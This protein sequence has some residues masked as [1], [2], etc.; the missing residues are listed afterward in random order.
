MARRQFN[1][2]NL[3]FLDVI[4]CG[5]GAVILFFMI[6]NSQVKSRSDQAS[7]DLQ[8]ESRLLEERIFNEQKQLVRITNTLDKT[9]QENAIIE[10]SV[11]ELTEIIQELLKE[12]EFYK[13]NS[14]ASD[15]DVKR[16][17][18]DVKQLTES[19]KRMSAQAELDSS[20]TGKSLREFIGEGDRQ[21]LT[22]LKLGG[23]HVLFLVDAS[24][25]MLG[26]TYVNVIRY[27]NMED[28]QKIKAPKW[29]Q[30][31]NSV[32][33]LTTRLQSGTKFQIYT[34]NESAASAIEDSQ[35]EWLEVD[36]GTTIKNAIE[37]LRSTVP[38]NG[39]SLIN[40]FEKIND[41]EP[42]PDNIFL[43]TDGLPTQGKRNPVS[44]TMVKPEQRIRYF[45]QALR[46]LPPIPVNVLLFPMDGDP[47][48]AEAYWRLAIRSKG[49][50]MAPSRDW[51]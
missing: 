28:S 48:A 2:F 39:T 15:D 43:L 7:S 26:R 16:L 29:R 46:E 38:Q 36:D 9:E 20:N 13:A 22:E 41:L 18:A 5:F 32:D 3:S 51:P 35:G 19:N 17:Q 45:E 37:E 50:F 34:F 6:I 44:E 27:R 14:L 23:K 1:V 10:G 49:S 31:V 12:I 33:W 11:D 25:S 30:T 21:Y 40:A 4:A 42:R 8:S 47:L 24:A